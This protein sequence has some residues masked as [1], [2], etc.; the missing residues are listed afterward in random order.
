MIDL[1]GRRA[2]VTGGSRGIG[3]AD[4]ACALASGRAHRTSGELAYHVLDVM[5]AFHDASNTGRH[6]EIESTCARPA[7]LPMGLREGTLDP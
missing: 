2:L 7:P 3:A 6:V 1:A 4:M 5:H